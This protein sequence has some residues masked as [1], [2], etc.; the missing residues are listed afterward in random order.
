MPDRCNFESNGLVIN[1]LLVYKFGD[2]ESSLNY[3]LWGRISPNESWVEYSECKVEL[4]LK[5]VDN[6][7]WPKLLYE[8]KD[9]K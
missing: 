9:E 3:E 2:K 6:K 4:V 5:Q 7:G 1:A 8:K